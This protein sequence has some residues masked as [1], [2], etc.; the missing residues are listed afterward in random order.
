MPSKQ[1]THIVYGDQF[2]S[3]KVPARTETLHAL[4]PSTALSDSARAVRES[5]YHPADHGPLSTLVGPGV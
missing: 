1:L 3:A 5:L 2:I 4:T